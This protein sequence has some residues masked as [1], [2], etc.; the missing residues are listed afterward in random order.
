MA[1]TITNFD[2][3]PT[4]LKLSRNFNT[5]IILILPIEVKSMLSASQVFLA[6]P[7]KS[8]L[9]QIG[10]VFSSGTL[11]LTGDVNKSFILSLSTKFNSRSGS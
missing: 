8:L 6:I 9:K 1:H 2:C 4:A 3:F 7:L 11:L 10:L 5:A